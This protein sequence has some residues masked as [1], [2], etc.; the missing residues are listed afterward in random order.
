M[1]IT[2]NRDWYQVKDYFYKTGKIPEHTELD[3]NI[4]QMWQ[5]AKDAG[6]SPFS[7]VSELLERPLTSDD[8]F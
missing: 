6:L 4:L 8:L 7:K 2:S 3:P 1:Q 5:K